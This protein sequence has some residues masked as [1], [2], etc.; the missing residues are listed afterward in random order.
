MSALK[1]MENIIGTDKIKP[2]KIKY[3]SM[4]MNS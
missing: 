3:V 4:S 1:L 2:I